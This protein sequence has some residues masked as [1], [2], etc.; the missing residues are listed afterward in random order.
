MIDPGAFLEGFSQ[1]LKGTDKAGVARLYD[2]DV[3]VSIDYRI[4]GYTGIVDFLRLQMCE[5]TV[6]SYAHC[7][8]DAELALVT[9]ICIWGNQRSSFTL[10]LRAASEPGYAATILHQMIA[11]CPASQPA[12]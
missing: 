7:R 11:K 9:G 3:R 6:E 8:L 2:P 4:L 1:L 12:E 10:V 5:F